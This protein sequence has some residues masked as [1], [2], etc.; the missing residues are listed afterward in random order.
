MAKRA[1]RTDDS[2]EFEG[3]ARDAVAPFLRKRGIEVLSEERRITGTA[4]SQFLTAELPGGERVRMKVRLCW[5]KDGRNTRE[6]LYSATQLRARRLESGWS[7]TLDDITRKNKAQGVTHLLLFQR[8]QDSEQYAALIPIDAVGPIWQA[9]YEVSERLIREGRLGRIKKNHAANGHSPTLWL[10]DNRT[11][12]GHE[13]A[14]ALWG[15]PGV[16]DLVKLVVRA[17][18]GQDDTFDDYPG[19]EDQL[20]KDG[21]DRIRVI[22]S[23]VQRDQRVREA[24]RRRAE[25]RCERCGA[26]RDFG[27]FLDVHHVMGVETSDRVWTCVALC[28][29]CHREAHVSPYAERIRS[30]L[31]EFAE[32]FRLEKERC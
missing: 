20:G 7:D 2:L 14:D 13:V 3:R 22:R 17:E 23:A 10:Q 26:Q 18:T 16:M 31:M 19:L 29:N 8:T 28:P 24:V 12:A 1:F 15:W 27:G 21:A 6:H 9:Q 5:R 32:S 11:D 25:G 30:E 4:V